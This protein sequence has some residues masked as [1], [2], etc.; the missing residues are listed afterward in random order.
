MPE[1][2]I[3]CSRCGAQNGVTARFCQR[4]GASLVP[5]VIPAA[6]APAPSIYTAAVERS[7]YGGFWI[8]FVA[9]VIDAAALSAVL[10]PLFVSMWGVHA[11][12]MVQGPWSDRMGHWVVVAPAWNSFWFIASWLYE[13]L[14]LSS[15]WQATL[16]KK[17]LGLR[18][19]DDYGQR[20]TF[21]RATGRHFA[22]Y[23]SWMTLCI[24]FL[25]I[26]FTER[27]QALHDFVAGTLV[28][29]DRQY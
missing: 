18:V 9:F 21:L 27:R 3:F 17:A 5:A 23:L 25:M 29:K 13:A 19:T 1:E 22:K 11:F 4:C 24:G 16:G 15:S 14:L 20:I 2:P 10:Y 12:R 28:V 8:R 26:A 7:A 6:T